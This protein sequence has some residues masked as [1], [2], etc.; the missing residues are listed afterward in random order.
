MPY[1]QYRKGRKGK[2]VTA[3]RKYTELQKKVRDITDHKAY[4]KTQTKEKVTNVGA[5]TTLSGVPAGDTI[6]D[7]GGFSVRWKQLDFRLSVLPSV[8]TGAANNL[9]RVIIFRFSGQNGASPLI[10]DVLEDTTY[11]ITSPLNFSKRKLIVP[12]HDAVY[13]ASALGQGPNFHR[14]KKKINFMTSYNQ[15]TG[16][17]GSTVSNGIFSF[18]LGN[19][20]TVNDQS[21]I[22]FVSELQFNE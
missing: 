16:G 6:T 4:S 18:I 10:D 7:R 9:I 11:P 5:F 12:I 15:S 21:E 2:R 22:I 19:Q 17:A 20:A 8:N 14:I 3:N 1:Y 13:N